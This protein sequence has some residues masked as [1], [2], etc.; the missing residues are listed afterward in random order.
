MTGN[1]LTR[2]R[3]SNVE[4]LNFLEIG[5]TVAHFHKLGKLLFELQKFIICLD[6]N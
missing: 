5:I 2:L 1:T 6:F 4:I 3:S